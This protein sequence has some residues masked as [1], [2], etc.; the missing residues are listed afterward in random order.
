MLSVLHFTGQEHEDPNEDTIK[1]KNFMHKIDE[2][3]NFPTWQIGWDSGDHVDI[4]IVHLNN[5]DREIWIEKYYDHEANNTK[6]FR[7]C[8][9]KNKASKS[10]ISY[11]GNDDQL[12]HYYKEIAGVKTE[13]LVLEDALAED[14]KG[15]L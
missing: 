5:T 4:Y 1:F 9:I 7:C 3:L 8:R 14:I 10:S 2:F 13:G 6:Q 15:M 11:Y 12:V